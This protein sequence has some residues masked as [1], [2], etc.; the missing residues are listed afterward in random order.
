MAHA[1]TDN[2]LPVICSLLHSP[3]LS[4][5]FHTPTISAVT[6]SD[7]CRTQGGH[8]TAWRKGTLKAA[9]TPRMRC[10]RTRVRA[11]NS[12]DAQAAGGACVRAH[13]AFCR[14]TPRG[15]PDLSLQWLQADKQHVSR[16]CLIKHHIFNILFERKNY[17]RP[18]MFCLSGWAGLIYEG[19]STGD[20]VSFINILF[21]PSLQNHVRAGWEK[22]RGGGEGAH[23]CIKHVTGQS[24]SREEE[25]EGRGRGRRRGGGR[26]EEGTAD[27]FSTTY[28]YL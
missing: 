19:N 5:A 15:M 10:G 22:R 18:N 21:I 3:P 14:Y 6:C 12:G 1:R 13:C 2:K 27:F 17:G 25:E 28:H 11:G 7:F 20:Y 4:H 8:A 16:R 24:I 23:P 9:R 26:G